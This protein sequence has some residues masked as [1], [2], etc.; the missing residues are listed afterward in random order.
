MFLALVIFTPWRSLWGRSWCQ[1]GLSLSNAMHF[2]TWSTATWPFIFRMEKWMACLQTSQGLE[3]HR[4]IWGVE[5]CSP[6]SMMG[7]LRRGCLGRTGTSF[8]RNCSGLFLHQHKTC[9]LIRADDI[10]LLQPGVTLQVSLYPGSQEK[11]KPSSI[12]GYRCQKNSLKKL[13][14]YHE[15]PILKC[16]KTMQAVWMLTCR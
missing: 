9:S 13:S 7:L 8:L 6:G 1:V 14:G 12:E 11:K 16:Q 5:W 4:D 3:L 15:V 2:H 10:M